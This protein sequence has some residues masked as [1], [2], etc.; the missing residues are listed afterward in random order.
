MLKK[1]FVA[2]IYNISETH[3]LKGSH[4]FITDGPYISFQENSI[5]KH[6]F[7]NHLR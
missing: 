7:N 1:Q 3:N 2:V 4:I 6:D 5:T